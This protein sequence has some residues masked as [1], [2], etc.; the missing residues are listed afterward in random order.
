MVQKGKRVQAAFAVGTGRLVLKAKLHLA[1][2]AVGEGTKLVPREEST[3]SFALLEHLW[4][5]AG[6][7]GEALCEWIS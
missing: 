3:R 6:Y 7:W 1:N 2:L 5:D 4:A